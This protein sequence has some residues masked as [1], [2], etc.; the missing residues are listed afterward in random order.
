MMGFC[1]ACCA[2]YNTS[3]NVS[4]INNFVKILNSIESKD[5]YSRKPEVLYF[6]DKYIFIELEKNNKKSILIK[7]IDHL[8]EE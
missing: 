8:F 6:N 4:K 3:K 7:K 2:L 5:C 1:I